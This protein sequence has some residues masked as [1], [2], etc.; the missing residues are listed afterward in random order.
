MRIDVVDEL[1]R[2]LAHFKEVRLLLRRMDL[3]SVERAFA[4]D[5]L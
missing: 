4:V 2:V 3:T 1:R 5:K